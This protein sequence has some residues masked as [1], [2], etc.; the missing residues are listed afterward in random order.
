MVPIKG[1]MCDEK[2]T[3]G[4]RLLCSYLKV[5]KG[6]PG[7]TFCETSSCCNGAFGDGAV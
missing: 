3:G 1:N 6:A 2:G 5:V 7:T 4:E